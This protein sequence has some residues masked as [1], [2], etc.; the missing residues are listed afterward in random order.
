MDETPNIEDD[1]G[2]EEMEDMLQTPINYDSRREQDRI[3]GLS[4]SPI[5]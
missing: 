4:R 5:E 1:D 2:D 3:Q